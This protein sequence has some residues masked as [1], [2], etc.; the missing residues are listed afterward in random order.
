MYVMTCRPMMDYTHTPLRSPDKPMHVLCVCSQLHPPLMDMGAGD[1]WVTFKD[2][3]IG[4]RTWS[5]K[6]KKRKI[7]FFD[8]ESL[9]SK[10]TL[11]SLCH[12]SVM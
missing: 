10:R 3:L 5:L 12:L 7:S 2:I 9:F 6:S 1:T 8:K 4:K 11:S